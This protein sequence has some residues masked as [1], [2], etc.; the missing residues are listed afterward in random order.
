MPT[1]VNLFLLFVLVAG[2]SPTPRESDEKS[3]KGAA[4]PASFVDLSKQ[5]RMCGGQLYVVLGNRGEIVAMRCQPFFNPSRAF[6]TL[7]PLRT[8]RVL[9]LTENWLDDRFARSLGAFPESTV[10]DMRWTHDVTYA[11]VNEIHERCPWARI[12]LTDAL[13]PA[14]ELMEINRH[15]RDYVSFDEQFVADTADLWNKWVEIEKLRNGTVP[16]E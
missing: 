2:C 9:D 1:G 3:R 11:R 4:S 5:Q 16:A 6:E 14:H 12:Y 15:A 10:I 13:I 7:P 8:V